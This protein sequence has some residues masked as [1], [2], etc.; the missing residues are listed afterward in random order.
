MRKNK[1]YGISK[2]MTP[3][4]SNSKESILDAG[5][6][7][8]FERGYV[9]TSIEDILDA[10]GLTKGAFFYHFKS[11]ND[12][13]RQILQRYAR[14]D[15]EH[16]GRLFER[17]D[18]L[19]SDVLESTLIFFKLLEEFL[20]NLEEPLGGCVYACYLAEAAHFEKDIVD[21][22]NKELLRWFQNFERRFEKLLKA[23]KPSVKVT[24]NE[25]ATM[26]ANMLQ[27]GFVTQKAFNDPAAIAKSV[28]LFR[29]FLEMLFKPRH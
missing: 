17:A 15:A 4:R 21:Y 28:A 7:L 22:L 18:E 2:N 23:R 19:S 27:G 5:Q 3:A 11:K 16:Y 20:E 26:V 10:T 1:L 25:L 6:N 8:I 9:G 24:A 12:L 29:T 14:Q 13:A